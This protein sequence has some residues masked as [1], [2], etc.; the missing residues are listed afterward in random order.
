MSIR[1]IATAVCAAAL[2]AACAKPEPAAPVATAPSAQEVAAA[3][4]VQLEADRKAILEFNERYVKALNTSDMALLSSLTAEDHIMMAPNA[5]A[6]VGKEANDKLNGPVL[7]KYDN[8]EVWTPLETEVGGDWAWQ[9]G[10]YD[11]TMTP[12][13]GK[14][15]QLRSVGKFLHIYRR[16]ADGSWQMIRDM[17]SSDYPP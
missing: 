2:F 9:R 1:S 14:G 17:Y 7:A 10:A 5:P 15:K 3:K 11:I 16:N 6:F 8:V 13:D 12:K 4:Q